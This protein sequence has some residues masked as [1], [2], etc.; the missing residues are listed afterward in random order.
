M[1]FGIRKPK[2]A[3]LGKIESLTV[4]SRVIGNEDDEVF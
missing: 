4:G 3:T 1:D 2:I